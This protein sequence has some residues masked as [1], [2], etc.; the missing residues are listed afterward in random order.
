MRGCK[1]L[2]VNLLSGMVGRFSSLLLTAPSHE[3]SST[4]N[5]FLCLN[6]CVP[7]ISTSSCDTPPQPLFYPLPLTVKPF[8]RDRYASPQASSLSHF[9]KNRYAPCPNHEAFP[10]NRYARP[11]QLRFS[12]NG[13]A[14][15]RPL[16]PPPTATPFL[17]KSLRP[18]SPRYAF[19]RPLRVT[20]FCI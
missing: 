16:R 6:T 15:I 18:P 17:K 5:R 12:L 11:R 2:S 13:Y 8:F 4:S 1:T 7:V 20:P 14:F 19:P 9:L 3:S 10:Y